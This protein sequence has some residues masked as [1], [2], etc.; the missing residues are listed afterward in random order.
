MTGKVKKWLEE[1]KHLSR[2]ALTQRHA[3]YSA[4][5]HG[6]SSHWE[7]LSSTIPDIADLLHPLEEAIQQ[8][9]IPALTGFPPCSNVD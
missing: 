1:A 5:T 6:L 7:F 8:H 2:I 3:A 4:Y 9:L